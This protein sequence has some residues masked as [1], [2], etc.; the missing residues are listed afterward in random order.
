[1]AQ[2]QAM[3]IGAGGEGLRQPD[4]LLLAGSHYPYGMMQ[5]PL[6]GTAEA[7]AASSIGMGMPIPL[8]AV[9]LQRLT[10]SPAPPSSH[11]S[12]ASP[13]S[14]LDSALLDS[15]LLARLQQQQ[16][17][18]AAAGQQQAPGQAPIGGKRRGGGDDVQCD[19]WG[20]PGEWGHTGC[21]GAGW[22]QDGRHAHYHLSHCI[23]Q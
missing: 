16:A 14:Q 11:S 7:A 8:R 15:S 12:N 3:R 10:G 4:D 9:H 21:R 2:L 18:A 20:G 1:M 22:G 6:A 5:Q 17:V 23:E 13:T 19:K